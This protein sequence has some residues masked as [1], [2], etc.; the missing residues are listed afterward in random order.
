MNPQTNMLLKNGE[1]RIGMK[2]FCFG[3]SGDCGDQAVDEFSYGLTVRS[4]LPIHRCRG[5]VITGR[6]GKQHRSR[7]QAPQLSQLPLV[8]RPGQ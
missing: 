1:I 2:H 7:Q 6:G 3:A 5:L 8:P 4:T